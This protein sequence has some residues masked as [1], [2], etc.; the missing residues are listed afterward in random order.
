M[1]RFFIVRL[2]TGCIPETG[3]RKRSA[4]STPTYSCLCTVTVMSAFDCTKSDESAEKYDDSDDVE[5]IA[6]EMNLKLYILLHTS[7]VLI[8]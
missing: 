3:T 5:Y 1:E 8:C 4:T 7:V 6:F 2:A